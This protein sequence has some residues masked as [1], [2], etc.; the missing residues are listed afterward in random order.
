MLAAP[1]LPHSSSSYR[2]PLCTHTH[3]LQQGLSRCLGRAAG[4]PPLG[5]GRVGWMEFSPREMEE[6]EWRYIYPLK[7]SCALRFWLR[8]GCGSGFR[9]LRARHP[10]S[11]IRLIKVRRGLGAGFTPDL[12]LCY[13]NPTLV[14]SKTNLSPKEKKVLKKSIAVPVRFRFGSFALGAL[15]ATC[16][17]KAALLL[18]C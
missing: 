9:C 16:E 10:H 14:K 11:S 18:I 5:R 13:L 12:R 2:P 4:M 8:D 3:S 7:A 15:E 17:K 1:H 6:A